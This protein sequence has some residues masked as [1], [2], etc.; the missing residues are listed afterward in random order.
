[1]LTIS[2]VNKGFNFDYFVKSR[3][4]KIFI[5]YMIWTVFY[6]LYRA[7]YLHN[8]EEDGKLLNYFIYGKANFHL[9][10]ILT[11]IQ[12]YFLFPIL[13]KFKKGWPIIGIYILATMANIIWIRME[14]VSLGGGGIE[15]FVND[16]LFIMNWIS[17]FMLG[18]V[19]AKFYYEI[20]E[21]IFK[22]KAILSIA[23][24]L[25][26]ID[27]LLSIDLKNLESSI[28]ISNMIYIPFF[29]VFLNYL[30]EHVKKN[31]AILKTL[32]LIGN[33]SM[34]IYLVHYV[35]IQF[36]KRLP[37]IENIAPQ[38]KFVGIFVLTVALSVLIVHLIGKLPYG[39]YI[40]PIPK[41]KAS[42]TTNTSV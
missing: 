18:I 9:Y 31:E 12:F 23:I 25:L 3:F 11:V 24:G 19:Y 37:V 20:R 34:G 7:F 39:N 42:K 26:L 17:F 13:Q 41:K 21:L 22:Y 1:L 40:V 33:Y 35:A 32:T 4:S 5:P 36:V 29:I 2:V 8:L 30:Y 6:L 28:T 16:K 10:F 38:S 15:R 14:S 27:F